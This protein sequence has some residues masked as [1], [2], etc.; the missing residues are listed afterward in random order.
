MRTGVSN[1]C[2]NIFVS[3]ES[4]ES[5]SLEMTK[6]SAL[7]FSLV[8]HAE[9]SVLGDNFS[10]H[11]G[12]GKRLFTELHTVRALHHSSQDLTCDPPL[13]MVTAGLG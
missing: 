3:L 8:V 4:V 10:T 13:D 6:L 7:S 11:L 2:Q 1:V 5:E 9:C 12:G